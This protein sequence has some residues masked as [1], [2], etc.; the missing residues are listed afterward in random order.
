MEVMVIKWVVLVLVAELDF[1]I[2]RGDIKI[3]LMLILIFL[4]WVALIVTLIK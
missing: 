4:Y 3:K 2:I 1:G